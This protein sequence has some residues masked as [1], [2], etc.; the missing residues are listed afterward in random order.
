LFQIGLFSNKA[1]LGAV[2][3]TFGLQIAVIYVPFLQTFLDTQALPIGEL[4]LS[5]AVST[6]VFWVIEVEKWWLRRRTRAA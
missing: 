1:A 4:F 2:L 6:I 5:L 3:L